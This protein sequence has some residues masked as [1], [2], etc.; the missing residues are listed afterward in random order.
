MKCVFCGTDNPDGA[1][2]CK[3]CGKRQD[4]MATCPSC[5]KDTPA[6][7]D[8]CIYCGADLKAAAVGGAGLNKSAS[9]SAGSGE[10][11]AYPAANISESTASAYGYGTADESAHEAAAAG[12]TVRGEGRTTAVA[13]AVKRALKVAAEAFAVLSALIGFIFVFFIGNDVSAGVGGVTAGL[14]GGYNIFYFFGDVYKNI[15]STLESS[16]LGSQSFANYSYMTGAVAGTVCSALALAATVLLFIATAVRYVRKLLKLTQKSATG[17]AAATFFSYA[18]GVAL[19][20]MCVGGC[21]EMEGGNVVVTVN[22]ATVAGLVLG[23]LFIVAS[24]ASAVVYGINKSNAKRTALNGVAGAVATVFAVIIAGVAANGMFS[25][26][27]NTG[28]GENLHA[29][30][31]ITEFF[32]MLASYSLTYYQ[33]ND[34]SGAKWEAFIDMFNAELVVNIVLLVFAVVF[35]ILAVVSV[36]GIFSGF[37]KKMGGRRAKILVVSGA[38]AV[39]AGIMMIVSDVLFV[40]W[41]SEYISAGEYRVDVTVPVV[42]MVFGVLLILGTFIYYALMRRE[43]KRER[44]GGVQRLPRDGDAF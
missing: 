4:G 29:M 17:L 14:G 25:I 33:N 36:S 35:C 21:T 1:L 11:G 18:F 44:Y 3:K 23:G 39:V 32:N 26:T 27:G 2:F 12:Y 16:G 38:C 41:A 24:A 13:A 30:L 5:G 20:M 40:N 8:F 6:D 43:E 42:V 22:G 37:G 19:F 34:D 15:E 28:Y 7:G 10:V 9:N 31:G